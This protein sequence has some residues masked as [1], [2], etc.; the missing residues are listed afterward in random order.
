[1]ASKKR[2]STTVVDSS[3]A[4]KKLKEKLIA[5]IIVIGVNAPA[6]F[7]QKQ[8]QA[9]FNSNHHA[10]PAVNMQSNDNT[11]V[12]DK[13]SKNTIREL[14]ANVKSLTE[15]VK[16]QGEI[17]KTVVDLQKNAAGSAL[18]CNQSQTSFSIIE[19]QGNSD[20]MKVSAEKKAGVSFFC[21]QNFHLLCC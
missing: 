5:E 9:L 21:K 3:N 14:S 8:L 7:S 15:T 2:K 16:S 1:M 19:T 18:S 4:N 20:A 6:T 11:E 17:L 10:I 13:I 12:N